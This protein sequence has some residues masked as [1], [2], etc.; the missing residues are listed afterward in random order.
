[1]SRNAR[2][3]EV[4]PKPARRT[5]PGR[6]LYPPVSRWHVAAV[7]ILGM[8]PAVFLPGALNRFVFLKLAL[9]AEAI[10]CALMAKLPGRL[11]RSSRILLM[12]A[13]ITLA[14]SALL[15]RPRSP[16]ALGG[17]RATRDWSRSP[18]TWEPS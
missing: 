6:R 14:S 1:V 11:Q 13:G 17:R 15:V 4:R 9:G 7:W 16:S 10:A 12:L 8:A 2:Q 3:T 5:Q 18:S